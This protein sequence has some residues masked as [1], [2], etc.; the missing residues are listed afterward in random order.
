MLRDSGRPWRSGRSR[1]PFRGA[2]WKPASCLP[3]VV[4]GAPPPGLLGGGYAGDGAFYH[5]GFLGLDLGVFAGYDGDDV[6]AGPE[7]D[8]GVEGDLDRRGALAVG[9]VEDLAAV[10][11]GAAIGH[12]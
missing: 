9:A 5:D 3:L 2:W 4:C 7:G 11:F 10:D 1:L 6:G 8:V 12:E